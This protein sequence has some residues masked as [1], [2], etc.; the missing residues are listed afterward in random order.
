VGSMVDDWKLIHRDVLFR[1]QSVALTID[2]GT[3]S[4][5]ESYDLKHLSS[6]GNDRRVDDPEEP[7]ALA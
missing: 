6:G 2:E 4:R 5:E 7:F 1:G 3:D